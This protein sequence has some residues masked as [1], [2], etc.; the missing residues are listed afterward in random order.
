MI[1]LI[2]QLATEN[3][4]IKNSSALW[5]CIVGAAYGPVLL[6]L[7]IFFRWGINL[8]PSGQNPWLSFLRRSVNA[9]S[10]VFLPM[11]VIL[12]M[13]LLMN[14]EHKANGWKQIFIQPISKSNI[15]LSKYL[16]VIAL[17]FIF[18]YGFACCLLLGGIVL[19]YWKKELNFLNDFPDGLN[20]FMT[21]L[22]SFISVLALIAIHFWLS[23]RIK[24]LFINIGLGLVAVLTATLIYLGNFQHVH[25]NPY[26]FPIMMVNY[27]HDPGHFLSDFHI[28]SLVYFF[29]IS[30]FSYW[31][32]T[33]NFRG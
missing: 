12:L 14:I 11:L 21:L 7:S 9:I 33:R 24:N 8:P 19:G 26:E 30:I 22:K 29:V 23:F 27:M 18:Y 2:R 32:F 20:I 13:A 5:L 15:F 3:I 6:S 25:F 17:I 1:L 28:Y 31:D 16:V 4:K 10:F